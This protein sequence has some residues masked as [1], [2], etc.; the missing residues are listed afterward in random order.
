MAKFC[1]DCGNKLVDEALFCCMCGSKQDG[2]TDSYTNKNKSGIIDYNSDE[3]IYNSDYRDDI[4]D[5]IRNNSSG[6]VLSIY[7]KANFGKKQIQNAIKFCEDKFSQSD[8]IV[9]MDTTVMSS[10]K[11]GMVFTYDSAYKISDSRMK[12]K[13]KFKDIKSIE[14]SNSVKEGLTQALALPVIVFHLY[15]GGK[16]KL[17]CGGKDATYFRIHKMLNLFS[18]IL[19]C[20]NRYR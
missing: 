16:A 10:M 1:G 13:V 9:L 15:N 20:V 7:T 4:E 8:V 18:E 5:T 2:D 11:D 14:E 19:A 12:F 17:T 3:F 6:C